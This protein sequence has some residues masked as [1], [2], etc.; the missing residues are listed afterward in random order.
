MDLYNV[1]DMPLSNDEKFRLVQEKIL[2][3][4]KLSLG[5][6]LLT[7][8]DHPVKEI[9]GYELKS[10]HVYRA[11]SEELYNKY[12]ELGYIY[13]LDKDDEYL[14]YEKN[15]Q[16]YNNN[17]GVD[18]YL[19]GVSLRYG[20]VIIECPAFKEY[21]R[22]AYDNGCHMSYDPNVRHMKS[23]EYKNPVPFSMIRVIKHPNMEID[24]SSKSL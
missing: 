16:L 6:S 1:F 9:N 13:G 15:G 19:G 17:R 4:T 20:S 3:G 2:N 8:R 11:I 21:F 14:E 22:P 5:E 18:W 7:G 23:S 12:Q 24:L 10:D